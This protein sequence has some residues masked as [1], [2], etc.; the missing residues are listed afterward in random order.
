MNVHTTGGGGGGGA[1]SSPT[2][3]L[4]VEEDHV[5]AV[6]GSTRRRSGRWNILLWLMQGINV[7]SLGLFFTPWFLRQIC[8]WWFGQTTN[9]VQL[10]TEGDDDDDGDYL[11]SIRLFLPNGLVNM[12]FPRPTIPLQV[13]VLNDD[14][15]D[16]AGA[17]TKIFFPGVAIDCLL[18]IVQGLVLGTNLLLR[19]PSGRL[20]KPWIPAM[21]LYFFVTMCLSALPLHC[22]REMGFLGGGDGGGNTSRANINGQIL[23]QPQ[24]NLFGSFLLWVDTFSTANAYIL[25]LFSTLI[26]H[27]YLHPT[28]ATSYALLT[29]NISGTLVAFGVAHSNPFIMAFMH[30]GIGLLMPPVVLGILLSKHWRP[31]QDSASNDNNDGDNDGLV[32]ILLAHAVFVVA[33]LPLL[34]ATNASAAAEWTQ[35]NYCAMT[36]FFVASRIATVQYWAFCDAQWRCQ[37]TTN[38]RSSGTDQSKTLQQQGQHP[39]RSIIKQKAS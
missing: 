23:R 16:D 2:P 14:N 32:Y 22:L 8:W 28:T 18:G 4:Q 9:V 1:K 25:V 21:V 24:P 37:I 15:D 11:E 20:S 30:G 35:G 34:L 27:Q 19:S 10:S 39:S 31:K 5:I 13:L 12:I 33:G 3:A 17:I 38:R 7:L 26:E 29:L 36:A 6:N